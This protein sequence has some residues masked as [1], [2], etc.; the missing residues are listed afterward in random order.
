[1]PLRRVRIIEAVDHAGALNGDLRYAINHRWFRDTGCLED[2]GNHIDDMGELLA[3]FPLGLDAIGP[4]NHRAVSSAAKVPCN[5]FGER[6]SQKWL[7]TCARRCW[8]RPTHP[9]E[10][11]AQLRFQARR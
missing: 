4:V 1:M 5:L 11:A 6:A 9:D 7:P 2:G 10:P 3:D 8:V